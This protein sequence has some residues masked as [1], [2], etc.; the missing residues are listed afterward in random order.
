[1]HLFIFRLRQALSVLNKHSEFTILT[2]KFQDC[3]FDLGVSLWLFS[4]Q[5]QW[6]KA[7]KSQLSFEPEMSLNTK[8]RKI[9]CCLRNRGWGSGQQ[10]EGLNLETAQLIT[11]SKDCTGTLQI[12]GRGWREELRVA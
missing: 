2:S 10:G 3:N 1:M 11:C 8:T 5:N 9:K 12:M 4:L 7:M 6:Q